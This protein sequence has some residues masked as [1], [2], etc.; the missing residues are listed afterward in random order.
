MVHALHFRCYL[1][2]F[3]VHIRVACCSLYIYIIIDSVHLDDMESYTFTFFICGM[4]IKSVHQYR[5][6]RVITTEWFWPLSYKIN[7]AVIGV[8]NIYTVK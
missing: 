2:V 5:L 1:T 7:F 4:S 8:K 3:R 6:D